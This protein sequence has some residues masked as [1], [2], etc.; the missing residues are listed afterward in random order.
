MV[1]D[2]DTSDDDSSDDGSVEDDD[3]SDASAGKG[4]GKGKD[5]KNGKKKDNVRRTERTR[6]RASLSPVEGSTTA[7]TARLKYHRR[8]QRK[9]TI[10]EYSLN[11]RIPLPS[12][13]PAI[14]DEA[15]AEAQ[16]IT[17]QFS[18]EGVPYAECNVPFKNADLTDDEPKANYRS[19]IKLRD[20]AGKSA[21]I[22]A[23]KGAECDVDL[24][25]PGVQEGV[26]ELQA[27][28]RAVLSEILAG[29]LLEATF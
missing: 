5:K 12:T 17:V 15:T 29:E 4:K 28:D 20:R 11:L 10:A 22:K 13:Q 9:K 14:S 6:I 21:R 19:R 25:E 18:R 2:D 27:G 8:A 26:P 23:K 24:L 1:E 16:E 3:N 7:A